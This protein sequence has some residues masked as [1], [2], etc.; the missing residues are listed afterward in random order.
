MT[1]KREGSMQF[2]DP[3]TGFPS[4]TMVYALSLNSLEYLWSMQ[5]SSMTNTLYTPVAM[6]KKQCD[7]TNA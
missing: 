4:V 2:Q 3:I 7:Y 1:K 6:F 5:A